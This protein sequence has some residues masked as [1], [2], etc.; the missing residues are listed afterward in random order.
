[1]NL[2]T[3]SFFKLFRA[4]DKTHGLAHLGK[5]STTDV[6]INPFLVVIGFLVLFVCLF[7][8]V[9]LKK[10]EQESLGRAVYFTWLWRDSMFVW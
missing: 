7:G 6:H 10:R 4:G 9:L 3:I 5:S 8:F 2:N 1:M